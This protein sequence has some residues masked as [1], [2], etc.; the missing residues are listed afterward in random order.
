MARRSH[1]Y[2]QNETVKDRKC[3]RKERSPGMCATVPQ[4]DQT[5]GSEAT[6][7]AV[8]PFREQAAHYSACWTPSDGTCVKRVSRT[9]SMEGVDQL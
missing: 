7:R 8:V 5:M 2:H 3:M 6:C 4:T 1:K 9:P